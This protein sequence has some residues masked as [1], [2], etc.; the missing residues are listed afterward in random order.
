MKKSIYLQL[1][2]AIAVALLVITLSAPTAVHAQTSKHS[3]PHRPDSK[4][5]IPEA[6]RLEHMEIHDGLVRATK[7]PGQVG[8]AARK[9]AAVLDPHF[10]REEQIALPPLGLLA[11]LSRGEF[12]PEMREVLSMTDALRAELPR[13]LS[14]H[15]AIR[16]ATVRLGE[17]AKAAGDATVERLAET[18]KVHAQSEEEV[19]YPAALLV[20]DVVRARSATG[21]N[22]R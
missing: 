4:I 1:F 11:P 16:A 10:V 15:K 8:E 3:E 21:T 22:Q 6:M 7:T 13:M 20:G 5:Q 9:L 17:V 18:L 19:F 14:E 12:T 2:G